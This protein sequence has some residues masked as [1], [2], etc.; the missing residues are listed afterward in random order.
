MHTN[1][2]KIP[3]GRRLGCLD[4]LTNAHKYAQ[5]TCRQM[6]WRS[7]YIN[8]CTPICSKYLQAYVLETWV[9]KHMHTNMLKIPSGRR[10]GD[11]AILTKT[12]KYDQNTCRQTFWKPCY[13]N[14]CTP[15]C[16][17]YLQ[18]DVLEILLYKQKHTNMFNIP[19]GRRFGNLAM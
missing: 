18:A 17:K 5:D 10:F 13:I 7:C 4:I 1:V 19:A 6:V 15:I 9:Y 11:L 2:L 16:S 3:A 12:H 14:T 8:K